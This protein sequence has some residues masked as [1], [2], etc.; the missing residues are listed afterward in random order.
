[1]IA[2]TSTAAGQPAAERLHQLVI[3][4]LRAAVGRLH[5]ETARIAGYHLGWSDT[6]D[7]EATLPGG[8][9]MLRASLALLSATAAGADPATGVPGAVAAELVHNFS[10]L[11]DDIMDGDRTRRGRPTAWAVYGVGSAVLTGDALLMLA[12]EIIAEVPGVGPAAARGLSRTALELAHGQAADL[13]FEQRPVRGPHAVTPAEYLAMAEGKTG[14]LFGFALSIGARLA[15]G[16]DDLVDALHRAGL[17]LGLA[18]QVFDDLLG[19]WGDPRTTG[20][21]A[22]GDLRRRKK[23]LPII[24]ALQSPAGEELAAL[25]EQPEGPADPA[26]AAR[27]VEAGG[28]GEHA[29]AE[30]R[31]RLDEAQEIIGAAST[32]PRAREELG[33]LARTMART[34]TDGGRPR[35]GD[36][37]VMKVI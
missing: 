4:A 5:L 2:T 10:L 21:P 1:M 23:T 35:R 16:S 34:V 20:K 17:N 37:P 11:H 15:G 3:P 19:I 18:F 28:G 12:Q 13:A 22:Y 32:D 6:A 33:A 27:L 7:G 24:A 9:K 25:L 30:A 31:R 29:E 14:A 36:S 8:G 26:L